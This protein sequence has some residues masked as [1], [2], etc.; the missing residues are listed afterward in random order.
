MLTL[1]TGG[2]IERFA[3]CR[4]TFSGTYV[5]GSSK[6]QVRMMSS[7][8]GKERRRVIVTGASRGLGR[9]MAGFLARS[10]WQVGVISRDEEALTDLV[11]ESQEI[12]A[13]IADLTD[14]SATRT[15]IDA[16]AESMGGVDALVN[17]AGKVHFEPF[18]EMEVGQFEAVIRQNLLTAVHATKFALPWLQ[19]HE[20][21]TIV[22]ISS[23]SGI[24]PLPGGSAYA[25]AKHALV[26]WSRSIFSELRHQGI[27]VCLI[28][29]GSISPEVSQIPPEKASAQDPLD[30]TEISRV[31]LQQLEAPPGTL[32][33]EVEIR[34]LMPPRR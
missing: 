15:A 27:R 10:G 21:A 19:H 3:F 32:L 2:G 33:S 1:V 12:S 26:G 13:E 28:H 31:V 14:A 11:N 34:P 23:I 9:V 24:Q 5:P 29:P 20:S 17:N 6:V 4:P 7:P 22:Q 8:S 25:A 16:L 30:P 18:C